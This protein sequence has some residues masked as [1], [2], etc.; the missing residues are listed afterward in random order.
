MPDKT[1]RSSWHN[2][3][4]EPWRKRQGTNI[5]KK[6]MKLSK[7]WINRTWIVVC[8]HCFQSNLQICNYAQK[9]RICHENSK[10]MPDENFCGHF[11]PRWKAANF[12]HPEF[13]QNKTPLADKGIFLSPLLPSL[14]HLTELEEPPPGPLGIVGSAN[15][16]KRA[17]S[18]QEG[19][20]NHCPSSH[21]FHA[22]L[23]ATFAPLVQLVVG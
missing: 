6:I 13:Y 5:K 20:P 10:Y 11:C 22:V 14:W 21:L 15:F 18:S 7:G 4:S 2:M 23:F 8:F 3:C 1:E 9:R 16:L 17:S 19:L 12:C